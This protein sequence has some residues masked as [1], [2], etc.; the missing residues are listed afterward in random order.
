MSYL[1]RFARLA[2]ALFVLLALLAVSARAAERAAPWP[3]EVEEAFGKLPTFDY[4][5]P[6]KPI[7]PLEL[8]IAKATGDPVLRAAVAQRLGAVLADPEA[9]HAAK[10]FACKHLRLVGS[11]AQVPALVKML[12]EAATAGMARRALESIPGDASLQALR[13]AMGRLEGRAR[14]GVVNSLGVRRDG[15]SVPAIAPLARNEDAELAGAALGAL[16]RIATPGAAEAL[17]RLAAQAEAPAR[18]RD[19]LLTC[20]RRLAADGHRQ[21][22]SRI[23]LGMVDAQFPLSADIA[24]LAGLVEADPKAA[25]GLLLAAIRSANEQVASRAARLTHRIPGTELTAELAKLLEHLPPPRQA[26]LIE[27]LA[28]RGD[29]SAAPAVSQRLDAEEPRLRAAAARAMGDLG[30]ASALERLAGLAARQ[31]G[32]VAQAARAS[33]A[34]LDAPG[35]DGR[36]RELAAKGEREVRVEALRALGARRSAAATP[37][38]L[39]AATDAEAQVA[40][41]AFE[42]LAA[43]APPPSYGKVVDLLVVA[44]EPVSATAAKAVLAVGGRLDSDTERVK[45]VLAALQAAGEGAKPRLLA[46]LGSLGGAEALSAVRGRLESGQGAVRDAAVRALAGWPTA[47][48]ADDVLRLARTAENAAHRVLALRGY[49]RMASSAKGP[50]RLE[51]LRRVRQMARSRQEKTMLLASLS[52]V[53]D[54]GAL[55]LAR[56]FL[57][58]PEVEEEAALAVRKIEE[59]LKPKPRRGGV[60]VPARDAAQSAAQRKEIAKAAPEGYHVACYLDCGPDARHGAKGGPALRLLAGQAYKWAGS[61]DRYGTIFYTNDQVVFE[62]RGLSPRRAYQLGFTWWDYDHD[63]RAQSVW[64]AAGDEGP[65]KLLG[66][67]AL[68]SGAKGEKPSSKTLPIPRRLSAKGQPLRIVFRNEAVP[69]VVV[70]ELWLLESDAESAPPQPAQEQGAA[71][72]LEPKALKEGRLKRVLIVTGVDHPGHKWRH[73]APALAELL[74]EDPRLQASVVEDPAALA[75]PALG[76]YDVVVLHFMPW[77]VEPPGREVREGLR[78]FVRQ[79]GG[80]VVVHFACGAFPGWEEY[81]RIAGRVYDPKLRAH[82]PRGPFRVRI[83]D[84]EHPITAGMTDF[85]TTDELYTCVAGDAEVTVLAEAKSKV[86]GKMYPMA[87]VLTYGKGRTFHTPLGHDVK[88]LRTPGVAELLRRGTAWAAGLPPAP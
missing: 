27:V 88:A 42:A 37:V 73:T 20:A 38:L 40:R 16:G 26:L 71:P 30:D 58:D 80:L 61:P 54:P 78:R 60:R 68:P 41:A 6:R 49:L 35:A 29:R 72:T 77:Q 75:S 69:N 4:D 70:S 85:E 36:L 14:I 24:V 66:K 57:D 48:P 5:Q 32:S 47:A 13:D 79:G 44:P 55:E 81:E 3:A 7:R 59:A 52:E 22:A 39:E 67:T 86:D 28:R 50:Q 53:A 18:S 11:D 65:A 21:A 10:L 82:D 31:G 43:A 62:A 2:S 84:V 83:T 76:R 8:T 25:R 63:T 19:A 33:L 64:L 1:T 74:G 15:Q 56:A 12:G 34:R 87:F 9:T 45:P 46:V 23:Y 17:Q 51:M